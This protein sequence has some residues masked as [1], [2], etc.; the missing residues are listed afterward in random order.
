VASESPGILAEVSCLSN[1]EEAGRLADPSYRQR[2]ARALFHGIHAYAEAR[3]RV[4][5]LGQGPGSQ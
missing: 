2:I 3:N 4:A 1:D 5:T